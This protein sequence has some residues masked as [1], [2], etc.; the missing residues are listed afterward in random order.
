MGTGLDAVLLCQGGSSILDMEEGKVTRDPQPDASND[1]PPATGLPAHVEVPAQ[2]EA[3]TAVTD[4][5]ESAPESGMGDQN[6]SSADAEQPVSDSGDRIN[7]SAAPT[8]D[9]YIEP[10]RG[11]ESKLVEDSAPVEIRN[12]DDETILKTEQMKSSKKKLV[13]K[14]NKAKKALGKEDSE[15]PAVAP[16]RN[17][18]AP[19]EVT[20]VPVARPVTEEALLARL[21][22]ELE[23]GTL[24][25]SIGMLNQL[26]AKFP[27]DPDYNSLLAMA[28]RLRDGD[29]WYQYSRKVD[30]KED[31]MP[32][33]N[34]P[35]RIMKP[36]ANETVN[37]LKK[38]SWF[39]IRS[40]KR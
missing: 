27:E 21:V 2:I 24:L 23:F 20:K 32:K 39:L 12:A 37:E 14:K 26:V 8:P 17:N 33:Q 30:I 28:I 5:E 38:S 19:K 36:T 40:A 29:V 4:S 16:S 15:M 7:R 31:K 1:N 35:V 6:A 3:E 18:T 34:A 13:S 10:N 11:R 9:P 22:K 25:N